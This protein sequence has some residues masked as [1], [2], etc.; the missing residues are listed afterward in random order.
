MDPGDERTLDDCMARLARGERDAFDPCFVL[1][2][3]VRS[4][5]L[6]CASIPSQPK[7]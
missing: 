1:S 7:M 4:G 3:R 5:L 2:L 6:G